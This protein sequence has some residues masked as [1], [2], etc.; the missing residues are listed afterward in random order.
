MTIDNTLSWETIANIATAVIALCAL[1]L[2]WWQ[3]AVSRNHNRLSVRPH[4]TLWRHLDNDNHRYQIDLLNN[5]IGP[6]VINS[7]SVMV[8]GVEID[9]KASE[10]IEKAVKMLFP[11]CLYR[12][13][14][15]YVGKNYIMSEKESR[16]IGLLDFFGKQLTPQIVHDALNRVDL[17]IEYESI[18]GDK[19]CLDTSKDKESA[20]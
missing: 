5:G 17:K 12:L 6:A 8:D 10:K 15:G 16:V 3:A 18:Y 11:N 2:T 20:S 19:D 7:F 4:L 13:E 1:G 14:S 9:G